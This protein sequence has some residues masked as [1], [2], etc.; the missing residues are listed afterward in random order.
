M[1]KDPSAFRPSDEE[2][3]GALQAAV[4][5]PF[6]EVDWG[7]LHDRI[8]ADAETH[9][10][11]AAARPYDMVM[12]WSSRGIPVAAGALAAA[13]AAA[14]LWIVPIMRPVGQAPPGFWPVAEEL[15]SS[16]PEN[17]RLWL[18]AGSD[19]D[20]LLTALMVYGGEER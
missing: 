8:M 2:L 9:V 6:G 3:K 7:R 14:L 13:A 5:K 20:S 12:A 4:R 10:R 16:L 18:S 15:I 19:E 17:T 1:T 11:D